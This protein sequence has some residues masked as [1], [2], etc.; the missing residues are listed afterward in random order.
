MFCYRDRQQAYTR[1]SVV[2]VSQVITIDK[3]FLTERAGTLSS[4]YQDQ[5]DEGLRWCC[6]CKSSTSGIVRC[7]TVTG[8]AIAIKRKSSEPIL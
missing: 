6:L 4:D 5:V 1:D 7:E 3:V 8:A 2:N